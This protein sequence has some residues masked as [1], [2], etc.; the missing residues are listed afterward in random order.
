SSSPPQKSSSTS[1]TRF[2]LEISNGCR[3]ITSL[4]DEGWFATR[5]NLVFGFL[6]PLKDD[7]EHSPFLSLS[8]SLSLSRTVCLS[9]G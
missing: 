4:S 1:G 7:N 3:I 9:V 6:N 2:L 8:L 5:V